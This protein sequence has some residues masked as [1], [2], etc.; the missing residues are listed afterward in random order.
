M[1]TTGLPIC[2][3]ESA[4][5]IEYWS[6]ETYRQ[7]EEEVQFDFKLDTGDIDVLPQRPPT[8]YSVFDVAANTLWQ[9][10]PAESRRSSSRA[11]CG[12]WLG[13]SMLSLNPHKSLFR[14][15]P[16]ADLYAL[17]KAKT[18]A[19][20]LAVSRDGTKFATVSDDRCGPR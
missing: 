13:E 9:P 6:A 8:S 10:V 3:C 17:A 18:S 14:A 2:A 7:P 15:V 19:H 11:C 16:V 5:I 12:F 1:L 20:S 4:G